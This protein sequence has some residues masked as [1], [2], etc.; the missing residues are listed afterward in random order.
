MQFN[1]IVFPKP[2]PSYSHATAFGNLLYI[3]KDVNQW[4]ITAPYVSIFQAKNLKGHLH[5]LS[6][7]GGYKGPCIPC[8]FLPSRFH[9]NKILLHF[10]GNAED[11]S[12][13][14]DL[15]K[16]LRN[17]LNINVLAMEYKGYGIYN[18]SCDADSILQDAETVF[19]Y[20]VHALNFN[21]QNIILYGRSIGSGPACYLASKYTI[22]SLILMSAFT[23]LRN[24]AK[25]FVGSLF[26]YLIEDRFDNKKYLETVTSPVFIIHGAKD[27]LVYP[28]H[29]L[30][31]CK[32]I[33]T[34]HKLYMPAEMD[35]NSFGFMEDFIFP[36]MTFYEENGISLHYKVKDNFKQ[37]TKDSGSDTGSKSSE[38][39]EGSSVKK[40]V[41]NESENMF[42]IPI[43][44]FNKPTM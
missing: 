11:V 23:S 4:K 33:K 27:N 30:E 29:A 7:L 18:G 1:F 28:E 39:E 20:L 44:G 21:P 38:D 24:V 36:L 5:E 34:Q 10:H 15:L 42:Y 3:P 37:N 14:K 19:S 9:S 26:Q 6:P 32:S 2:K 22:H 43:K 17:S 25:G 13:T 16:T 31:L 35:H 12:L 40:E 8:F 41:K